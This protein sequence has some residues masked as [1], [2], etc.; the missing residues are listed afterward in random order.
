MTIIYRIKD[1]C[2]NFENNRTR[3]LRRM[4]FVLLPNRMDGDGYTE[5]LDHPD[6]AAHFGAWCALV[7]VASKCEPRGELLRGNGKPHNAESLERLTRIPAKTFKAALPRLIEIGWVA[8]RT[9]PQEG[10]EKCGE[11]AASD[12]TILQEG[13][14][15]CGERRHDPAGGCG[16]YARAHAIERNGMEWNGTEHPAAAMCADDSPPNEP[17]PVPEADH[18]E[19]FTEAITEAKMPASTADLKAMRQK[20][21]LLPLPEQIAAVRHIRASIDAGAYDDPQYIP[22]AKNYLQEKRWERGVRRRAGPVE[23][24]KNQKAFELFIAQRDREAG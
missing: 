2:K 4:E 16:A 15:K 13:A 24:G 5:L 10:A 18:W 23:K 21:R 20:W 6:G 1:W 14:E 19:Q 8:S 11:T 3:D 12:G 22:A 7:Q 9:I 17:P